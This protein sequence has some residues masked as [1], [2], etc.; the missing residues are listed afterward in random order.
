MWKISWTYILL[1]LIST[2][3]QKGAHAAHCSCEGAKS[4]MKH[5]TKI[6]FSSQLSC[7]YSDSAT[8]CQIN[9]LW[10]ANKQIGI[11]EIPLYWEIM[12][13][14]ALWNEGIHKYLVDLDNLSPHCALG[15]QSSLS[16]VSALLCFSK[17]ERGQS[18]DQQG[19]WRI[20]TEGR[21]EERR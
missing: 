6:Y 20:K 17:W 16:L 8:V 13:L 10:V 1:P 5:V 3:Q 14:V 19:G 4:Y 9:F 2:R 12:F 11:I 18:Q 21:R 15:S 7:A